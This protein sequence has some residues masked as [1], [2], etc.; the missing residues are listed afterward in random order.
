MKYNIT[1]NNLLKVFEDIEK[2]IKENTQIIEELL[3]IDKQYCKININLNKLI[4]VI[5][6][7]KDEKLDI[8]QEQRINIKY[9]GN[10]CI[11]LNLCILAI[12]TKTTII[13][14]Y[15]DNMRAINSLIIQTINNVLKNYETDKLVYLPNEEKDADKIIVVDDINKYN[16]YIRQSN[17]NIKFYS[18]NYI[19]FYSDSDE[20]EEIEELIYKYAEE[21]QIPIE[22]YSELQAKEAV[23]MIKNGLGKIAV[24]L[25]NSNETKQLFEESI[26]NK[27]LYINKNPFKENIRLINKEIFYM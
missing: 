4:E 16:S 27:K 10:P 9:N 20:Y 7:L 5:Q 6:E 21:N 15:E 14:D 12:L 23:Q 3:K 1:N 26:T 18:H 8:Q 25:T 2:A 19:D 22:V 11:T 24:V 13:L 17:K